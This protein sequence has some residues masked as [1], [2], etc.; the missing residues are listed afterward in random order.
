MTKANSTAPDR[1][2]DYIVAI[3]DEGPRKCTDPR[4]EACA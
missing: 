3:D 2:V 4:W 1:R